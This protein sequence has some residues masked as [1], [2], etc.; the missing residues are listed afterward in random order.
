MLP[1]ITVILLATV[2]AALS[3]IYLWSCDRGLDLTDDAATY[4]CMEHPKEVA[5][6]PFT[7]FAWTW[8]LY[9]VLGGSIQLLRMC[10]LACTAISAVAFCWGF[11]AFLET[12]YPNILELKYSSAI[13]YLFLY[14]GGLL[15]FGFSFGTLQY[16]HLSSYVI[17][18]AG[19]LLLYS[20][21]S[22][23]LS[24]AQQFWLFA[25]MGFIVGT[26]PFFKAS[27]FFLFTPLILI[28]CTL[29]DLHNLTLLA[30]KMGGF[31][32]GG[33]AASALAFSLLI[34]PKQF[35]SI[36][37]HQ[38]YTAR[39]FKWDGSVFGRHYKEMRD[40]LQNSILDFAPVH[41]LLVVAP[42]LTLTGIAQAEQT[43]TLFLIIYLLAWAAFLYIIF[44]KKYHI[45][46]DAYNLHT[47]KMY[48]GLIAW[49]AAFIIYTW[50][51]Q[52][53]TPS[54]V[55]PDSTSFYTSILVMIAIPV[56]GAFGTGNYIYLNFIYQGPAWFALIAIQSFLVSTLW[57][58]SWVF[59]CS[60]LLLTC[61]ATAQVFT[62][63]IIFPY[64][65]PSLHKQ[66]TKVRINNC[67][68]KLDQETA[69]FIEESREIYKR[70]DR[71][72]GSDIIALFD[73]PGM[74][75]ALGGVSPG[76]EWYFRKGF[77]TKA[78]LDA[79][80]YHLSNVPKERR[81]S[82]CILQ[83]GDVSFFESYMDKL[84]INLSRY[85]SIGETTNPAT[86]FP[87]I[88]W[89]PKER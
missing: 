37:K 50:T 52:N 36:V 54:L 53:A 4:M 25:A 70:A 64:R 30:T 66:N 72:W 5:C 2:A 55:F 59:E 82:A 77:E 73:L 83:H 81:Q 62:G 35:R 7:D 42:L 58:V 1:L 48:F 67:T 57:N 65:N 8:P 23:E 49:T 3:A 34:S 24:Q 6:L 71:P 31:I 11:I 26:Q 27:S 39:L 75:Y 19:G 12:Y 46:G 74:V 61:I 13:L 78:M 79:N 63:N 33:L 89:I 51:A 17:L 18:T 16:N 40:F 84:G 15:S 20:M 38:L 41:A 14:I 85:E 47:M 43:R 9:R 45:S 29:H 32:L 86:G 76:H 69:T 22:S 56:V 80:Y 44:K 68:L 60:I 10:T 21:H 28:V 87:V 88:F